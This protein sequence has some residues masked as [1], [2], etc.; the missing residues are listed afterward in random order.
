MMVRW[1]VAM[2][3]MSKLVLS[4]LATL[5]VL[6]A[7]LTTAFSVPRALSQTKIP[8]PA[9]IVLNKDNNE[10]AIVDPGSLKVLARVPTGP[11]PHEVAVSGD[12]K[13]AVTTNYGA[14]QDGKTLS[15]IDLDAQKEIHRVE[16]TNVVG[17]NGE[18]FGELIGPHGI[19]F[20]QDKFW[21]TA[22]G[23]KK[24]ARYDAF[25]NKIDWTH[26][27]G[28]DRTHMLVISPGGHTIYTSNVNS[29]TV[30][31][32]VG[33]QDKTNWSNT[34]IT[35]G[36]G[37]EGIDISPDGSEVWAANSGDGTVSIIDT[38]SK[39][40]KESVNVG[41]K[42]SNRVKFTP[43]GRVAL[44]SDIGSGELVVIETA[45]RKEVKRLKLGSS[46]AGILIVPDGSK[47]YV[48]VSGDNKVAVIDLGKF[49]LL[50]TFETGKDPDG[51]AWRQ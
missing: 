5:L 12:G 32:V 4:K 25:S 47:A 46:T 39:K 42:H 43:D 36:K 15:V 16:L 40:V 27:I 9:L 44:I 10:L 8:H 50:K 20:F 23:S 7:V 19:E 21:F 1:E 38:K 11:V 24:I 17:P 22:E 35:V 28:Q 29:N 3:I 30:T 41:T 37:P 45:T 6:V 14:H 26:D 13:T 49:E 34:V 33:T 18:K 51:L 2:S 31:A 48:A